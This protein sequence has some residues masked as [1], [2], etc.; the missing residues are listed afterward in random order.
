MF[1]GD[2]QVPA[3]LTTG[4]A[5][6]SEHPLQERRLDHRQPEAGPFRHGRTLMPLEIKRG[7]SS[8][9]AWTGIKIP[10]SQTFADVFQLITN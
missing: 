8:T 5:G 9:V 4:L 7:R 1:R 10:S 2:T 3:A 6:N